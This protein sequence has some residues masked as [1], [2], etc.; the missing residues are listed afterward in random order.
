MIPPRGSCPPEG[1]PRPHSLPYTLR[2]PVRERMFAWTRYAIQTIAVR[3]GVYTLPQV[4]RGIKLY[5]PLKGDNWNGRNLL[6][7]HSA[8]RVQEE[9]GLSLDEVDPRINALWMARGD[10]LERARDR[11][12]RARMDRFDIAISV[13]DLFRSPRVTLWPP[14]MS[15]ECWLRVAEWYGIPESPPAPPAPRRPEI[16]GWSPQKLRT[17]Y[18]KAG[19]KDWKESLVKG[20]FDTFTGTIDGR[21]PLSEEKPGV[22][23]LE[24][25]QYHCELDARTSAPVFRAWFKRNGVMKETPTVDR[26]YDKATGKWRARHEYIIS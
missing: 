15:I 18:S 10:L 23:V 2:E 4:E 16:A 14:D 22:Y 11:A 25:D 13:R 5:G 17:V 20:F 24:M 21:Y 12:E 8:L 1:V 9:S 19:E 7:L 6:W 3:L 26:I